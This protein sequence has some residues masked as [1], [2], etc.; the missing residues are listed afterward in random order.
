MSFLALI[1]KNLLRQPVRTGLAILGIGIGITTIVALGAITGGLKG[2]MEDVISPGESD[3][4]VGQRGT[5]DF[6]FSTVTEQELA[7]VKAVPEVEWAHGMLVHVSRVGNN[8]F[9]VIAGMIPEELAETD[10]EIIEGT[11][12]SP[13]ATSEIILG[14]RAASDLDVTVG[15]E[16]SI[17]AST[18]TVVGIHRSSTV[19]LDSGALAPL[20]QVQELARK[21]DVVTIAY[22]KVVDSADPRDVAVMIEEEIPTLVAIASVADFG[23]IDQGFEMLDAANLAISLLAV[24]IGAIGVMNTMIMSVFERTR[25]FGVLRAVGWSGQRIIRMIIGEAIVLCVI[26]AVVGMV[27]GILAAQAILLIGT[28]SNFLQLAY[29]PEIFVRALAVAVIVALVGAAY[30]VFRAIRLSP[31][32]ALRHE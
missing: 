15:D 3:F 9:F 28:V 26:A 22:V 14:E 13:G 7:A 2:S 24:G 6:T 23:E 10:P 18:F 1:L 19:W 5:A 27:L 17:D 20:E 31:M 25:E 11:L 4:I 30:P 8:P 29:T 16:L 21:P 12:I 32:E